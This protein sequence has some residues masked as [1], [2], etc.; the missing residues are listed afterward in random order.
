MELKKCCI[1]TEIYGNLEEGEMNQEGLCE[2]AIWRLWEQVL[3]KGTSKDSRAVLNFL[4]CL[5]VCHTVVCDK[6]KEGNTIYQS[7]SPD[8]SALVMAAKQV[9]F[10]LHSWSTDTIWVQNDLFEEL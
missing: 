3:L 4:T 5:A 7:S 8:E 9:G 6:D 2:S 10:V 1:G